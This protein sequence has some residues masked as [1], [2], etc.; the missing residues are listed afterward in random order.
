MQDFH[1]KGYTV[2]AGK[3]VCASPRVSHRIADIFPDPEKFDPERY[4]E[5]RQEDALPFSWIAF[6]GGKHKCTGNAFAMLQLKAIFSILL[7]RYTFELI[8][9]KDQYQDDFTQMVVQPLSPCRVRYIKRTDIKETA[10]ESTI[11]KAQKSTQA[12]DSCFQIILD[13]E[14]CQGHATCMTE[15]PEL[16]HVDEAGNVTVLQENP[17]LELLAKAGLAEKYCPSKAIKIELK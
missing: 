10:V 15:A 1:F 16:F 7:R 12:A 14:L 8:D 6:G 11:N 2:K 17:P 13:R 3:Y 9:D 5:E 4:S